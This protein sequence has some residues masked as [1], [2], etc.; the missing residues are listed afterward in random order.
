[1]CVYK[2][3]KCWEFQNMFQLLQIY[4]QELKKSQNMWFQNMLINGFYFWDKLVQLLTV[5]N[6]YIQKLKK[7]T[8]TC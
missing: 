2:F 1:M 4:I 6:I 3:K 8:S 5:V 7:G